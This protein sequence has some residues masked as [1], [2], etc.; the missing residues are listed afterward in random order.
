GIIQTK[1]YLPTVELI[2]FFTP[3]GIG[4][5][6]SFQLKDK[7][8]Q[9]SVFYRQDISELNYQLSGKDIYVGVF[10]GNYDKG[11]HE[12]SLNI[13]IHKDEKKF[14]NFNYAEPLFNTTNLLEMGGQEY[15]SLFD[16]DKG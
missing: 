8:W 1:N 9:E 4:H 2:R 16:S 10:I 11:G 15:G 6:N 12:V 14:Y 13:T 7:T 5:F 3:F